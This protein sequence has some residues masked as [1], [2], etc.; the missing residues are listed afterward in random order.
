VVTSSIQTKADDGAIVMTIR[1]RLN[2][3]IPRTEDHIPSTASREAYVLPEKL[4]AVGWR[5]KLLSESMDEVKI[6]FADTTTIH[7]RF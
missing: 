4:R 3:S 7:L 6:D 5:I 1:R 2:V